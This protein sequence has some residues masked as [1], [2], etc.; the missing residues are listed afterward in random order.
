MIILT[1]E[2]IKKCFNM[3]EAIEAAKKSLAIYT[4]NKAIV[5][6][7]NNIRIEKSNG[8]ILYM[9]ASTVSDVESSGIKI[10]SVY[11]DNVKE[12]LPAVPATMILVDSNTGIVSA[13][14][15]GTYLTQLR[16]GA[17]QGAATD[18]LANKDAQI[19]ALIGTGGQAYQ[20]AIAMLT[21]RKLKKL[22]VFSLDSKKAQEF[23]TNLQKDIE[24]KFDTKIELAI[25]AEECVKDADIITTVTTSK[26]P[27][28]KD[29]FVKQGAH[30]N[31]VG[32]FTEEMLE[33]PVETIARANKI[34]FD[35]TDG[36]MAEAGDILSA[37]KQNLI[38][39]DEENVELGNVILGTTVGRESKEEITLFKTV[40]TAVLDVVTAQL[41]FEKA[42]QLGIGTEIKL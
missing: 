2:D 23:V 17:V 19:G 11:P 25:S 27:T 37:I 7:R 31:G 24:G 33:M 28:F 29:E 26:V 14:L 5:P 34:F 30:V 10:V 22:K 15:D 41:I 16:T 36:V 9:P 18:I 13:V 3:E 35:T 42:K 6:L 32:A 38:T 39:I 8:N 1:K 12:N 4:D 40:G 21:V 20:Q